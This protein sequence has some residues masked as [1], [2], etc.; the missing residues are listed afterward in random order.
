MDTVVLF[1]FALWHCC[2]Q[3]EL[4][5]CSSSSSSFLSFFLFFFLFCPIMCGE[6]QASEGGWDPLPCHQSIYQP[7]KW[8]W[9]KQCSLG[10]DLTAVFPLIDRRARSECS[11]LWQKSS[12]H[13][14]QKVNTVINTLLLLVPCPALYQ[15]F[16]MT[17]ITPPVNP[18]ARGKILL[19]PNL[20][21]QQGKVYLI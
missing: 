18:L 2:I 5:A 3:L 15:P 14:S 21:T 16:T 11:S 1:H 13:R 7:C 19:P 6:T 20:W 10:G 17:V 12:R 8:L 9:Q 4:K